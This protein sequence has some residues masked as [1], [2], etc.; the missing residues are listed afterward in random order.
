MISKL[1]CLQ[2]SSLFATN[3][4]RHY[5]SEGYRTIDF[6]ITYFKERIDRVNQFG[7]KKTTTVYS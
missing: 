4:K 6:P 1:G 5:S 7:L 3:V 2:R